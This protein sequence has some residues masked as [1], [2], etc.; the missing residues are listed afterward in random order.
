MESLYSPESEKSPGLIVDE[1]NDIE[2]SIFFIICDL[3]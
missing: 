2:K 3:V 1:E